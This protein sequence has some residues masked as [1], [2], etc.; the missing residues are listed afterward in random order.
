MRI[1]VNLYSYKGKGGD[2]KLKAGVSL[3]SIRNQY[4]H[5]TKKMT[6]IYVKEVTG[7][8][9]KDILKNSTNF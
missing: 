3:D 2:D 7:F 9:K 5:S 6:E 4:G 1:D 8:Y